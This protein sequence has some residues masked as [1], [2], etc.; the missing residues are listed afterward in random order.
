MYV[1]GVYVHQEYK[2][3]SPFDPWKGASVRSPYTMVQ[4]PDVIKELQK[5]IREHIK[6]I[7]VYTL[8]GS[9]SY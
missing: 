3:L 7:K 1:L 8:C 9:I 5:N 6:E 2:K 4:K